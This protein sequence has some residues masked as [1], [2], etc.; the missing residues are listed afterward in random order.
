MDKAKFL[1]PT[2]YDTFALDMLKQVKVKFDESAVTDIICGQADGLTA[3]LKPK[4]EG[5][6]FDQKVKGFCSIVNE[7]GYN[8]ALRKLKD[9]YYMIKQQNCPVIAIATSYDQLCNEES[10]VYKELLEVEVVCE[11]RIAAGAQSCNYRVT[12]S[13]RAD[14]YDTLL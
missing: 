5:F 2:A 9:G 11:S 13:G 6:E 4:L 3:S 12:P 14:N 1:F 10:G 8:I 7:R